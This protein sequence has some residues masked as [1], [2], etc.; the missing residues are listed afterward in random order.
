MPFKSKKEL[1]ELDPNINRAGRIEGK[2]DKP[3][4]RQLRERELLMLLRKIKPQVAEAIATAVRIMKDDKA[5]HQNQLKAAVILL[6]NYKTMVG[7]LYNEDYD[8]EEA[9]EI[10]QPN[11]PIFSLKMV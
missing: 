9:E 4:N 7:D 8:E 6:D 2:G 11:A 5:A 3:T 10:Q 1:G